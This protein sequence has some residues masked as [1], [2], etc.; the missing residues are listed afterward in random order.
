MRLRERRQMSENAALNRDV[1]RVLGG[2]ALVLSVGAV[3]LSW[4]RLTSPEWMGNVVNVL[5]GGLI[6][7]LARDPKQS[8]HPTVDAPN[9]QTVNVGQ[10]AATPPA[11]EP[12]ES[13]T[14]PTEEVLA[15]IDA[16]REAEARENRP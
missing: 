9:A 14:D 7:Y 1:V 13:E 11:V 16:R 8:Q 15:S 3:L 4:N 10:Q 5:V 6:G 2:V 12:V